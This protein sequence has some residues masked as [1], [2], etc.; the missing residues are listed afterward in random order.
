MRSSY[1]EPSGWGLRIAIAVGVLLIVGA[2]ALAVYGSRVEP[3]T[4]PVV[5]TVP[6]DQLPR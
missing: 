4:H 2:V 6:N 5:Q 1:R 3:V